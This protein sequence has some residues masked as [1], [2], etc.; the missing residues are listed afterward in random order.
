MKLMTENKITYVIGLLIS[1]LLQVVGYAF[2][3]FA[4]LVYNYR[5]GIK[6]A[7]RDYNLVILRVKEIEKKEETRKKLFGND[8]DNK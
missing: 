1:P 8:K 6:L 3:G 2:G 7:E 5:I 4:Q